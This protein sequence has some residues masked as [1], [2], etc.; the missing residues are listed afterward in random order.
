ME[1]QVLDDNPEYRAR[2]EADFAKIAMLKKDKKEQKKKIQNAQIALYV[3]AGFTFLSIVIAMFRDVN[4]E[5]GILEGMIV[6]VIYVGL[7]L[8]AN[9]KPHIGLTAGLVIFILIQMLYVMIDPSLL[10]RGL[11]VKII[12]L[13]FLG[14][15]VAAAFDIKKTNKALL[16]L[17]EN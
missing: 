17:G 14:Q 7:A 9:S 6:I 10:I 12:V 15:G 11:L 3:L 2:N 13:Y 5:D 16:A 1:N 4:A 8:Y